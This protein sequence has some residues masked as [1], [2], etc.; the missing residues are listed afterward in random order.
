MSRRPVFAPSESCARWMAMDW[1]PCSITPSG[2][3]SLPPVD[4]MRQVQGVAV[5]PVGRRRR[6]ERDYRAFVSRRAAVR[7][8]WSGSAGVGGAAGR[9]GS[10]CG[11]GGGR[12]SRQRCRSQSSN[13]VEDP[14]TSASTKIRPFS[15]V[16]RVGS[17]QMPVRE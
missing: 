11:T 14:R 2:W 13:V 4:H 7:T 12:S 17:P 15:R 5:V 9:M 10:G 1:A 16:A 3:T 6:T 8:V